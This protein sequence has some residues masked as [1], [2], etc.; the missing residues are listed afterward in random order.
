M[1]DEWKQYREEQKERRKDRL[2]DRQEEIESLSS[3]GY[4]VKK[5]T[6]FQYRINGTYDLYPIHNRWHNLKT[7]KRGGAKSLKEFITSKLP[8]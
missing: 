3:L 6:E 1:S 2:P 4:T 7:Q 8:L 5:I